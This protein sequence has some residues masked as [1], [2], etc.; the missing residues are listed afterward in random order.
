MTVFL[1]VNTPARAVFTIAQEL[2]YYQKHIISNPI[3][4]KLCYAKDLSRLSKNHIEIVVQEFRK[5]YLFYMLNT[6][7][8][9][10]FYHIE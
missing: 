5:K 1:E 8:N 7:Y 2:R 6:L 4:L 3:L 9:I 10:S